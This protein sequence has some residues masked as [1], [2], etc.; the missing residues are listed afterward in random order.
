MSTQPATTLWTSRD[1]L[2]W[3]IGAFQ[4]ANVEPARL[5]AETLVCHV[6]GCDRLRLMMDQDRPAS[7][8]ERA[9]LRQLVSRALRHEPVQYLVGHWSFYGV[10]LKVDRRAL[11][12]RPCTECLVD[13]AVNHIRKSSAASDR[14]LRVLDMCTGT[15]C[16][17]IAIAKQCPGVQVVATDVSADALS[18]ASENAERSQVGGQVQIVQG[19][20]FGALDTIPTEM[21]RFDVIVSNP[22]YIP[23]AEWEC[24]EPRVK[25]F[26][27]TIALRGGADGMS[28]VGRLIRESGSALSA[29]GIFAVELTPSIAR[30]S[31]GLALQHGWKSARIDTDREGFERFLVCSH[32]YTRPA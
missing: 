22:P 26:E 23:D 13:I 17:A 19:D 32:E 29:S 1:L 30:L 7:E 31:E 6:L 3:I 16:I 14:T 4:K 21:R 18:L 12:P 5:C 9:Q 11:I 15:G 24:V 20:L 8:S 28:L 25:D 2:A 10:D 27:P